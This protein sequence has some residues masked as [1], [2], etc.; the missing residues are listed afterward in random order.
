M[1][2]FKANSLTKQIYAE[3]VTKTEKIKNIRKSVKITVAIS[4]ILFI[5]SHIAY[6]FSSDLLNIMIETVF[7]FSIVITISI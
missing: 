3:K 5:V 4:P 6:F 1:H 2:L 7:L